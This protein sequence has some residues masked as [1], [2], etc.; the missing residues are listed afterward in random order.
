MK[1]LLLVLALVACSDLTAPA[2]AVR[3]DP[4]PAEYRVWWNELEA[5]SG[6]RSHIG[7][8]EFYI[9]PTMDAW[10]A[11][12]ADWRQGSPSV[13]LILREWENTEWLVKHEMMHILGRFNT[14]PPKYFR[15]VCGDL[16]GE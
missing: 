12:R 10:K 1:R 6:F 7:S 15:G 2:G 11:G 13:I 3:I 4:I 14:H 9:V 5:C 16:M 8:V